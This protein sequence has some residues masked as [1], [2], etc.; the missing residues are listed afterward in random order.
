MERESDAK[1]C[2]KCGGT[3]VV[4]GVA[5]SYAGSSESFQPDGF[6]KWKF[7]ISP[8]VKMKSFACMDCGTVWKACNTAELA[9]FL[10]AHC[11]YDQPAA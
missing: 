6:N 1:S 10:K 5:F 8:G 4:S 11:G 2:V 9:D 3:K 7:T